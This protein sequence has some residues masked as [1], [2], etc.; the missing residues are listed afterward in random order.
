MQLR[1]YLDQP[2][3]SQQKLADRMGVSQGLISQWLNWLEG[4]VKN[5][6]KVAPETAIRIEAATDGAVTCEEL[7]QVG[8]EFERVDG[9]VTYYRIPAPVIEQKAA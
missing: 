9:K 5:A 7:N 6:S 8:V 2:E 3:Q 4:R 1:E